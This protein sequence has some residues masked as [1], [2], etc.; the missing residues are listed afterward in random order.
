MDDPAI[1]RWSERAWRLLA[2]TLNEFMTQP[3]S[4]TPPQEGALSDPDLARMSTGV[5]SAR[6]SYR[7]GILI[8]LAY[9]LSA[10]KDDETAF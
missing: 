4:D 6:D 7:D 1:E 9:A 3:S 8:Q 2:R 10:E 5:L